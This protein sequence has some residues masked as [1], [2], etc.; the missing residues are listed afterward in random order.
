MAWQGPPGPT[1]VG[2]VNSYAVDTSVSPI[3]LDFNAKIDVVFTGASGAPANIGAP[4]TWSFANYTVAK[5]FQFLFNMTTTD[6]QTMPNNLAM[7]SANG[8]WQVSG[9]HKWTPPATGKYIA[10]GLYDSSNDF[11]YLEDMVGPF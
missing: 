5:R 6:D 11:W 1:G 9:L 3:V 2:G 8:S 7:P 10:R 4:K